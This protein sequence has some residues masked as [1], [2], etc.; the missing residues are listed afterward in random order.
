MF[1]LDRLLRTLV[2]HQV[3][4]IVVGGVAGALQGG[5]IVTLDVDVCCTGS[6]RPTFSA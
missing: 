5:P 6:R 2:D 1:A 3:E 4:F